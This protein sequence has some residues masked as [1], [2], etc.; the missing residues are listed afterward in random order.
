MTE[1]N[2]DAHNIPLVSVD[3][4]VYRAG[5]TKYDP[6]SGEGAWTFGGRWNPPRAFRVIYCSSTAA[7]ARKEILRQ[8]PIF[9]IEFDPTTWAVY[10]IEVRGVILANLCHASTE[11]KVRKI[12]RSNG[13]KWGQ[14]TGA[15]IHSLRP[16]VQGI[17]APSRSM[18]KEKTVALF[19]GRALDHVD[20]SG[21]EQ[22]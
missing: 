18:D 1:I 6:L 2:I 5:R 17:L 20:L 13:H 8:T 9:E 14:A 4:T 7:A 12:V 16:D 22:F 11:R 3:G 15:S 21:Y 19:R 10:E